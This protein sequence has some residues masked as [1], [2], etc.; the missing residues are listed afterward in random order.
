MHCFWLLIQILKNLKSVSKS[1]RNNFGKHHM[2]IK[3]NIG[4]GLIGMAWMAPVLQLD[5]NL[6]NASQKLT[7]INQLER[8][9]EEGLIT[10]T[11][12][13]TAHSECYADGD[14]VRK[15]KANQRI[16]TATPALDPTDPLF[17]AVEQVLFPRGACN[18]NQK[19]D[20]RIVCEAAKYCAILVT[21]DGGSKSQPGGMLGNRH[22]LKHLVQILSPDE[23]V[24]F[25]NHKMV[26]E[27]I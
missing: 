4:T 13:A 14:V 15:R 2:T 10:I 17:Q 27:M 20:I 25:I 23:A 19:N 7:A 5:T 6:I 12:S 18:E 22:K 8:W 3:E 21:S 1:H 11:M 9:H 26:H 24:N 16:F